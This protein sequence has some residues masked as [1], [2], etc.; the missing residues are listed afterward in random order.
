MKCALDS[1]LGLV[2]PSCYGELGGVVVVGVVG[3][4]R[5][6]GDVAARHHG[7]LGRVGVVAAARRATS[8][9]GD[10]FQW[11]P[12]ESRR[13]RV[14]EQGAAVRISIRVFPGE[15]RFDVSRET[16][17]RKRAAS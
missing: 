15:P 17:T 11:E 9:A 2:L 16:V 6:I 7:C 10:D 1:P 8:W 4:S 12:D 5:F 13:P 3:P 14:G